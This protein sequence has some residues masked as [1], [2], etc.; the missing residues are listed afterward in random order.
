MSFRSRRFKFWLWS[1]SITSITPSTNDSEGT[2]QE[3]ESVVKIQGSRYDQKSDIGLIRISVCKKGSRISVI[4]CV[5]KNRNSM[6]LPPLL[7]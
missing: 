7:V 4:L 5:T 1:K 3:F 2:A 6:V